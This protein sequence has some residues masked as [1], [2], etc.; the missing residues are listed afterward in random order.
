LKGAECRE[1]AFFGW[2][3]LSLDVPNS[4]WLVDENGGY[5]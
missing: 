2:A 1:A 5:F 3:V 4:H